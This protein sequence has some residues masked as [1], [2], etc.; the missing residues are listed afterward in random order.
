ME[1]IASIETF[2]RYIP[3]Y[4][5]NRKFYLINFPIWIPLWITCFLFSFSLPERDRKIKFDAVNSFNSVGRSKINNVYSN[6]FE[7]T[8]EK[9]CYDLISIQWWEKKVFNLFSTWFDIHAY[10]QNGKKSQ[11]EGKKFFGNTFI[12]KKVRK[13]QKLM[14]RVSENMFHIWGVHILNE[15]IRSDFKSGHSE[16]SIGMS[17]NIG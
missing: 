12:I 14:D 7:I 9:R 11:W 5:Q 4:Y 6:L 16:L 3:F 15:N 17:N 8:C 13:H 10:S 1:P 2:S